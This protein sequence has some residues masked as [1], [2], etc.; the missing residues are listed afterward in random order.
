[1]SRAPSLPSPAGPARA[2]L[3]VICGVMLFAMMGL[4]VV[5]V[6]GRYLFSAPLTGA[7]E[8]TEILLACVI[9]IGLPAVSLDDEHVTVDLIT[10]K[11]PAAIQPFRRAILLL[12][13]GVVLAVIAWRLWAHAGQIAGYGGT[14]NS[15]R[16]PVAPVA[17]LCAICTGLAAGITFA[18]AMRPPRD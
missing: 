8:L 2:A 12:A 17:Y 14:T 10:G 18:A 7:T 5:D 15:L 9:F 1:M 3:G 13:S 16:L 11:L 6:I 4:T